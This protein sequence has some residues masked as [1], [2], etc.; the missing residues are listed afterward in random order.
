MADTRRTTRLGA[1]EPLYFRHSPAS[2]HFSHLIAALSAAIESERDIEESLW[3]DP[4]FDKWL[5]EAEFAWESATELC[6][7][8]FDAP[9]TRLSD[10][11]LQRFARH[12]H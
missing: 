6:R 5:S 11:P 10:V 1:D 9:A 8:V 4:A 7:A 2:G 3:S 12:L